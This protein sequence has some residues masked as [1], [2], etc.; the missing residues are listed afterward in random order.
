MKFV[1]IIL[2]VIV[3]VTLLLG[4]SGLC[5][6]SLEMSPTPEQQEKTT[7][8]WATILTLPFS[9][10]VA[11][12][13]TRTN[14][15]TSPHQNTIHKSFTVDFDAVIKLC[16]GFE[17]YFENHP[18]ERESFPHC[19]DPM[20]S[21]R[22]KVKTREMFVGE[23]TET[24]NKLLQILSIEVDSAFLEAEYYLT[25]PNTGKVY[26]YKNDTCSIAFDFNIDPTAQ[27]ETCK[28]NVSF[29]KDKEPEITS[30]IWELLNDSVYGVK[31]IYD[32]NLTN[33]NEQKR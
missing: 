5:I 27:I 16:A 8:A 18:T 7:I 24:F 2:S 10:A 25:A 21:K 22:K 20:Q 26:E 30:T 6:G 11:L 12:F 15:I 1:R 17:A 19:N 4:I 31:R 23:K 28:I 9:C 29:P 32:G 33:F 14:K 3:C 13:L